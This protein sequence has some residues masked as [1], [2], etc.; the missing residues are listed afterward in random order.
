M[1]LPLHVLQA[2]EVHAVTQS[3]VTI[4]YN[5]GNDQWQVGFPSIL[6]WA[7][8]IYPFKDD[9]WTTPNQPGCKFAS[10][11]EPNP[12]LET[13]VAALT[14]GPV[15]PSDSIGNLN[16][17]LI[18]KTCTKDGLLLKA[19]KP[20]TA[21][22]STFVPQ[23][24]YTFPSII[25]V[26]DS[27]TQFGNNRWHYILAAQLTAG[28]TV[29]TADIGLTGVSSLVFDYFLFEN[30]T[31]TVS[32]FDDAHSL[33]ISNQRVGVEEEASGV[34]PFN[35]FVIAP[36]LQSKW[37]LLGEITK[38]ITVSHQR[39]TSLSDTSSSLT[40]SL[41]G[42]KGESLTVSLYNTA[43]SKFTTLTPTFTDNLITFTCTS[44][45]TQS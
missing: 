5:P 44:Q 11:V 2:V 16:V 21:I 33:Q 41:A 1:P 24:G 14:T 40:F 42:T 32:P 25:Q 19:D 15:G 39:I 28:Y 30:G 18:M 29:R 27:F 9:F 4:D 43:T 38:F 26:W 31:H 3:R 7:V 36:I 45:C 20:T 23:R 13:L 6:A 35:Y 12:V 22:D 34:V 8:G 37:V 17:E 10:C